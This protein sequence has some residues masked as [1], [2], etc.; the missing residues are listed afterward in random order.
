MDCLIFS[1]V[2]G[3][4][5]ELVEIIFM[6]ICTENMKIFLSKRKIEPDLFFKQV[7]DNKMFIMGSFPLMCLLNEKIDSN[8]VIN[9]MFNKNV[10]ELL[11]SVDRKDRLIQQFIKNLKMYPI[12]DDGKVLPQI[13]RC[14]TYIKHLPKIIIQFVEL[15]CDPIDFV[16]DVFDFEIGKLFFDGNNLCIN[17]RLLTFEKKIYID[18]INI[19]QVLSYGDPRIKKQLE[20]L[21]SFIEKH[22][23]LILEEKFLDLLKIIENIKDSKDG[24]KKM[25]ELLLSIIQNGTRPRIHENYLIKAIILQGEQIL[26]TI[27][28]IKKYKNHGFSF[29]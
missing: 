20:P 5:L 16:N 7:I 21:K 4:P 3:L 14:R 8:S 26:K 10:D 22:K 19:T 27:K 29:V 2:A 23:R 24:D 1:L 9:I 17:N 12:D 11:N 28:R 25:A 18:H 15:Q 13:V 6:F